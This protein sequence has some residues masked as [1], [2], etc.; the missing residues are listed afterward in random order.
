MNVITLT[1]RPR[2]ASLTPS[3]LESARELAAWHRN[4]GRDGTAVTIQN[5]VAEVELLHDAAKGSLVIVNQAI[6]D[7]MLA[8][9]KA[10]TLFNVAEKLAPVLDQEIEDRQQGGNLD[11]WAVLQVL[12]DE[13][14]A[15]IRL[16]KG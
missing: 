7:K 13:L 6:S 16:V 3:L 5:L 10:S 1:P 4:E 15:A 9:L 8:Q 12:S 14:H 11:D 2:Q